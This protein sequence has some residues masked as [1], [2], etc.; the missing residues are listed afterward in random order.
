M[1]NYDYNLDE[2]NAQR[3]G[4]QPYQPI[5]T[6][7]S[8]SS[9][10]SRVMRSVY[11][12]M[13]LGL[14]VTAFTSLFIAG[15]QTLVTAIFGSK[16]LF[17]GLMIAELGVVIVLSSMINKLS[18]ATAALLFYLYA[19]LNGVVLTSI[20][21]VYSPAAIFKTFLITAGTFGA[22]SIYGY[23]TKQDLSKIG[24]YLV[25]ALIGLIVCS[26][27]NIFLQSTGFDWAI[28]LLGVA[29]F[30]GLTAWD[31]QKIKAMAMATDEENVGKLATMGALSL[32]LDFINLFLYLLRFFGRDR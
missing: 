3:S 21:F 26:I 10:V 17:F 8:L 9:Y 16:F 30:V 18:S 14:L 32:Y 11:A 20:L 22:M 25:M 19:I 23:T 7:R 29:I 28:S 5:D 6:E 4:Y 1:D 12:R 13:F 27:V 24:S 15:N 31:T 2:L